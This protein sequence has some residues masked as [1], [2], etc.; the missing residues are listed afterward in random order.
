MAW[1]YQSK[2]LLSV[3]KQDSAELIL[4]ECFPPSACISDVLPEVWWNVKA[5]VSKKEA[6]FQ[7]CVCT[8]H[9]VFGPQLGGAVMQTVEIPLLE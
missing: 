1:Q 3:R 5:T 9:G 7:F 6:T 8:V 2:A 4:Y